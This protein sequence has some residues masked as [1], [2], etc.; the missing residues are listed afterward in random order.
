MH[1]IIDLIEDLSKRK[2]NTVISWKRQKKKKKKIQCKLKDFVHEKS[3]IVFENE[4]SHLK[5]TLFVCVLS[6]AIEEIEYFVAFSLY[7]YIT[8]YSKLENV[9]YIRFFWAAAAAF[10][11]LNTYFVTS[12]SLKHRCAFEIVRGDYLKA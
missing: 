8:I 2:N 6:K 10:F 5:E 3:V 9:N 12:S 7:F 11:K 4:M 1:T